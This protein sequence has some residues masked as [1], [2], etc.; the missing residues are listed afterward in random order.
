MLDV[1]DPWFYHNCLIQTLKQNRFLFLDKS[2]GLGKNITR[3]ITNF[4]VLILLFFVSPSM[5]YWKSRRTWQSKPGRK[6]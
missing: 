1:E 2:H 4:E 5:Q 6:K 3:A